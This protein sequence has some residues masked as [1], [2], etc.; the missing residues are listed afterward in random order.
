MTPCDVSC[1]VE[2]SCGGCG[3]V[4][5]QF[6]QAGSFVVGSVPGYWGIWCVVCWTEF[7]HVGCHY[8]KIV[9]SRR[10]VF[11]KSCILLVGE[12]WG[13][14]SSWGKMYVPFHLR[15]EVD[16]DNVCTTQRRQ[17]SSSSKKRK[18]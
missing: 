7:L 9:K 6:N 8:V 17:S 12:R 2:H 14:D 3:G 1:A 4:H 11:N 16:I 18:I 13:I 5:V 15:E 10:A